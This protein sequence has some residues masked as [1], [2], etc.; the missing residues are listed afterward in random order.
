MKLR[1]K[2]RAPNRGQH[3]QRLLVR[4]H[5][6]MYEAGKVYEVDPQRAKELLAL[7]GY[8]VADDD[9]T[10]PLFEEVKPKAKPKKAPP[11]PEPE[12]E[13]EEGS[14]PEGDEEGDAGDEDAGDDE[15]EENQ[16]EGSEE[17][18]DAGDA[19]PAEAEGD[20]ELDLM[21]KSREELVA[22][23]KDLGIAG[24]DRMK[25]ADLAEAITA[26]LEGDAE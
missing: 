26:V 14:E 1:M 15:S 2:K 6:K 10:P 20:E 21:A 11:P 17:E 23:A 18:G 22:D 3:I 9:S 7:N 5:G 19:E 13:S 12:P 16:G 24:A 25:K 4:K 8:G